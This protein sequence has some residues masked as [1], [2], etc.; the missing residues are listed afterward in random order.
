MTGLVHAMIGWICRGRAL[1]VL[2]SA[3]I[4]AERVKATHFEHEEV[5]IGRRVAAGELPADIFKSTTYVLLT[6]VEDGI[7]PHPVPAVPVEYS[8]ID[9]AYL[10]RFGLWDRR[11]HVGHRS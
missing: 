9:D 2:D 7:A 5:G 1:V 8:P 6:D 4:Q 11:C 3:A 10:A